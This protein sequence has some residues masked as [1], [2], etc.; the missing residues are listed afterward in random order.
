MLTILSIIIALV[1]GFAAAACIMAPEL[2]DHE[3]CK[4]IDGDTPGIGDKGNDEQIGS[5]IDIAA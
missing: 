3:A 2:A 4:P 5:R 1:V